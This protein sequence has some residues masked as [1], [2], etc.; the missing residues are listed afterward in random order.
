MTSRISGSASTRLPPV[1]PTRKCVE[2][3]EGQRVRILRTPF[4]IAAYRGGTVRMPLFQCSVLT[5]KE[6]PI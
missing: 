5:L 1:I 3:I 4:L 6:N 2:Y